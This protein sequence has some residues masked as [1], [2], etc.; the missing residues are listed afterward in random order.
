M[1]A[2]HGEVAA[3]KSEVARLKGELAAARL[4]ARAT[5]PSELEEERDALRRRLAERDRE[6]DALK[7]RQASE[8]TREAVSIAQGEDFAVET[9]D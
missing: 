4:A 1:S 6:L 9:A 2:D 8:E 7:R 5:P 3:L